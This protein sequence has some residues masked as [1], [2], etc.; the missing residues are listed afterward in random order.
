MHDLGSRPVK[1][2]KAKRQKNRAERFGKQEEVESKMS[3]FDTIAAQNLESERTPT[4]DLNSH[5]MTYFLD[6]D[7]HRR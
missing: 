2:A 3:N 4:A 5:G 6:C 1:S 7:Y